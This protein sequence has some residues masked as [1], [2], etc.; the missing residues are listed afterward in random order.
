MKLATWFWLIAAKSAVAEHCQPVWVRVAGQQLRGTFVNA[1]GMFAAQKAA[2]VEE[3]LQQLQI[4]GANF[5]AQEKV[6]SQ[7]A[8]DIL[9]DRAGAHHLLTQGT[10]RLLERVQTEARR[11]GR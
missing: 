7:S 10:H 6:T 8:V 3:K 4:A 11:L 2:M 5:P 9:D 1:F